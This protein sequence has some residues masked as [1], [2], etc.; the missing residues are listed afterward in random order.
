MSLLKRLF[1]KSGESKPALA[2]FTAALAPD[3]SFFAI[4]DIHGCLAQMQALLDQVTALNA[5]APIIFVGDYVDRGEDSAAVLRALFALRDDPRFTCLAGNHEDMMLAFVDQPSEKGERWLRYGGMQTLASFGVGGVSMSSKGD[6]ITAAAE[7]LKSA[8]GP[9]L[10]AWLRDLPRMTQNGNVAVVHAGA[11]PNT[12]IAL[13]GART[14]SWGHRDFDTQPRQDG[15]WVL[16]GHTIVDSPV[17]RDGRIAIDTGAYA[18]GRLTAAYVQ[19][20][21]VQFLST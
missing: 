12:P 15:I 7:A 19:T 13:Q 21:N 3:S 14:L 16:H 18:T 1:R 10:L 8:M 9:D 20:G 5:E 2:P 4:G 17:A 6:A 11:D